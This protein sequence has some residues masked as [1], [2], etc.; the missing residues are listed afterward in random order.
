MY[1]CE[2]TLKNTIVN[3]KMSVSAGEAIVI[4]NEIWIANVSFWLKI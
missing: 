1:V 2:Y 3:S 4:V